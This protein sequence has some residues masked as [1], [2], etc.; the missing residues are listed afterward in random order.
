VKSLAA[1]FAKRSA[2]RHHEAG[3]VIVAVLWILAALAALVSVYS[4]LVVDTAFGAKLGEDRLEAETLIQAGVELAVARLIS[5]TEKT[6]PTSG[7]FATRIG[8]AQVEVAFLSEGARVDLNESK[9]P[10]LAG[11]LTILGADSDAAAYYADR[12]IGWRHATK[13]GGRNEEIESYQ[14]AGLRSL[15]RQAAFQ[16]VAELRLV[17]DLP[18]E[19]VD[20]MLPHVTIFNGHAEIDPMIADPTILSALP[21]VSPGLVEEILD[22]RT[23]GDTRKVLDLLGPARSSASVEARKATRV[24]VH[25]AFDRGRRVSAEVVVLR[26]DGGFEPYRILAWQD[27]FDRPGA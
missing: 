6:P 8:S 16:N 25:I 19:V 7:A 24:K 4:V 20:R 3:F 1:Q 21:N 10:L 22:A 9:Q 12:I 27:D 14:R 2:D 23:T 5:T 11:L 26:M 13:A 18:A 15:P 17:L